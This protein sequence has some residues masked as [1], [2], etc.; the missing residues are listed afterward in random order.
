M[1]RFGF[2][3]WAHRAYFGRR[4]RGMG[5]RPARSSKREPE[6]DAPP[7]RDVETRDALRELRN[8]MTMLE[9]EMGRP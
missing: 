4:A 3:R 5:A 8:A 6:P 9:L 1:T 7:I 2:D